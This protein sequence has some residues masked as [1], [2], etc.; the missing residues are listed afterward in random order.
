M[1]VKQS[2]KRSAT[3][4]T[5][6]CHVGRLGRLHSHILTYVARVAL[7]GGGLFWVAVG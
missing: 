6:D 7:V 3:L 2:Q 5:L 1:S 4:D